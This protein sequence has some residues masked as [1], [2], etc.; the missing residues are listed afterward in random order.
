MCILLVIY[1]LQD[2]ARC[3]QR[4][5]QS[6]SIEVKN[7]LSCIFTSSMFFISTCL[8][9]H[10]YLAVHIIRVTVHSTVLKTVRSRPGSLPFLRG[11]FILKVKKALK[12]C[13]KQREM[14]VT[15]GNFNLSLCFSDLKK[16]VQL[17][18]KW[19]LTLRLFLFTVR[20]H[21]TIIYKTL[22]ERT[23]ELQQSF[24]YFLTKLFPK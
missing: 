4:Q 1:T 6:W 23:A 2:E 21:T 11:I 24:I 18:L 20:K 7:V 22:S 14:N 8:I 16:K 19:Y 9:K 17:L 12:Y 10:T 5:I 15:E 3:L 13:I